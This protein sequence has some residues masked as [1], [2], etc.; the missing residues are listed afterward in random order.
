MNVINIG[1]LPSSLYEGAKHGPSTVSIILS[2]SPPGDGPRLHRHPYD[3]TWIVEQGRVHVWIGEESVEVSTGDIAVAPPNTPHKF[4]NVGQD[5]ARLVCIH[6]S[7][8]AVT[9]WLE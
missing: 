7:P 8:T 3:E 2:E 9:E 6:G 4:K 1:S 5:L